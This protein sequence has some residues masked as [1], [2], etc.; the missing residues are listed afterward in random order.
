LGV[1][2]GTG[3]EDVTGQTIIQPGS[4]FRRGQSIYSTDYDRNLPIMF[5]INADTSAREAFRQASAVFRKYD[6]N[7]SGYLN[8]KA[9]KK[10]FNDLTGKL[11]LT[12]GENRKMFEEID[13]NH[14][15]KV[16]E[17]EFC[18]FYLHHRGFRQGK[19]APSIPFVRGKYLYADMYDRQ[20]PF[21]VP[22]YTDSQMADLFSHASAVFRK[23]DTNSNG[24][25]SRRDFRKAY[26]DLCGELNIPKGEYRRMFSD[27]G[28][29]EDSKI[30]EREFCEFY[31]QR[32]LYNDSGVIPAV[33]PP[34]DAQK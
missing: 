4:R 2:F 1:G 15:G 17:R 33:V 16:S 30:T 19:L 27:M 28:K 32:K 26:R 31:V 7:N 25:L 24:T 22:S 23:Y 3:V 12:R 5:P 29:D 11:V 10:A 13:I 9:F 20:K 18:E 8:K 34:V 14:T 21:E 6:T